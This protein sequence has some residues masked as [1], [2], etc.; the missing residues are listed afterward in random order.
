MGKKKSGSGLLTGDGPETR[1][2]AW[3]SLIETD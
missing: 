3:A 1:T 2:A